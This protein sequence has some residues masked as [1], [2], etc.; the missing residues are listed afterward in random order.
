MASNHDDDDIAAAQAAIRRGGAAFV[1]H[2]LGF[3][4]GIVA[5]VFLAPLV[6]AGAVILAG[7]SWMAAGAAAFRAKRTVLPAWTLELLLSLFIQDRGL[8]EKIVAF[9]VG[10]SLL[11]GGIGFAAMGVFF[12]AVR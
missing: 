2:V 1:V 6:G 9:V 10:G 5:L 12:Y 4:F 7:L 8:R 11:M 3:L